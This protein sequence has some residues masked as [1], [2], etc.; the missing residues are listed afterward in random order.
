MMNRRQDCL[1]SIVPWM[2]VAFR[3]LPLLALG[4]RRIATCQIG[5]WH[6]DAIFLIAIISCHGLYFSVPKP[7]HGVGRSIVM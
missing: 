2:H 5:K 4:G 6:H 7:L 3:S 1:N